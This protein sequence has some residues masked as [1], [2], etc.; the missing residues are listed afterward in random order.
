MEG[1]NTMHT[2][3]STDRKAASSL[4]KAGG[5]LYPTML[6]VA[7]VVI[8]LSVL[9]IATVMGY[10]PDALSTIGP[11]AESKIATKSDAPRLIATDAGTG[12]YT[13]REIARGIINRP[14]GLRAQ[15]GIDEGTH[16]AF[17]RRSQPAFAADQKCV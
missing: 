3:N 8:I 1:T 10:I 9:G 7:I 17:S 4:D 5:I 6:I 11:D 12:V 14:A 2:A 15:V 13:G 16:R